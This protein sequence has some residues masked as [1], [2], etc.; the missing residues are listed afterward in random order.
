MVL[1]YERERLLHWFVLGGFAGNIPPDP[2]QEGVEL[3]YRKSEGVRILMGVLSLKCFV[4]QVMKVSTSWFVSNVQRITASP[5]R[6]PFWMYVKQPDTTDRQKTSSL[7]VPAIIRGESMRISSD[8]LYCSKRFF[9]NLSL[10]APAIIQLSSRRL[11]MVTPL[12]S[13]ATFSNSSRVAL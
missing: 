8:S 1:P 5:S 2:S 10:L 7:T 4:F 6:M 13:A 12:V 3:Y 9:D 11:N